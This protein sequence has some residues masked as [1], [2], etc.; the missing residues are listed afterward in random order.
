M[1]NPYKFMLVVSQMNK[2]W[3]LVVPGKHIAT[4]VSGIPQMPV[5]L[6]AP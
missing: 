3:W 2:P 5:S 1:V 6:V 4:N